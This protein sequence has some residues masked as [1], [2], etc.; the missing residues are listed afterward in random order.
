M[1]RAIERPV[2]RLCAVVGFGAAFAGLAVSS[3]RAADDD[4]GPK[5]DKSGY[6]LFNPVPDSALRSFS[7]DR[8]AKSTGPYTVDAGRVQ[9]ESDFATFTLQKVDGVRTTTVFGPNP[10]LKIGITNFLD[11]QM[12]LA[13][14]MALR[15]EDKDA[16]T[17]ERWTGQS[18][19][20]LRAKLNLWGN[21]GG[22][23]A[24]ALIPYVKVPTAATGLG[25]GATEGGLIGALQVSLP[26]DAS[27]LVNSEVDW[28]KD[29]TAGGY[30][31]NYINAIGITVPVVK[32][33]AFTAE[34]WSQIT[35]DP[36]GTVRQYSADIALAWTV[37]PNM[38]L[39]VGANFGL[40][41]DTPQL[42]LYSGI[43]YRF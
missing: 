24:F 22:K 10:N 7:P 41:K 14:F 16:E 4:D 1:Q 36:D 15:I 26:G 43:A 21:E 17:N 34:L 18:D 20:F 38:Q 37:R 40:N 19:L 33:V 30:H 12:N 28:Q 25:N 13:P 29:A 23:T 3:A 2:R 32:D 42:Q 27:L 11:F 39:D 9:L 6:T 8:P 35:D 5:P 31:G